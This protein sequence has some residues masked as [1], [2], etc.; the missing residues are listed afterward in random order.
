MGNRHVGSYVSARSPYRAED[1]DVLL[2]VQSPAQLVES[3]PSAGFAAKRRQRQAGGV[4]A[5][6]VD[7]HGLMAVLISVTRQVGQ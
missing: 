5:P 7:L 4:R 6:R 3:A 1:L 2:P